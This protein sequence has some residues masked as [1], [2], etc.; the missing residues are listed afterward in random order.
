MVVKALQKIWEEVLQ[1]SY[2]TV[3]NLSKIETL[4]GLK[5]GKNFMI[6]YFESP[7]TVTIFEFVAELQMFVIW[8]FIQKFF[9][10]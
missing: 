10:H 8:I 9:V 7:K 3:L 5:S 2:K 1:Y 6:E 4:N